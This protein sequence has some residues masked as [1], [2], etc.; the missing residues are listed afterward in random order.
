MKELTALEITKAII[1]LNKTGI[2]IRGHL[3]LGYLT[4]TARDV[5]TANV[6]F[7]KSLCGDGVTMP[8]AVLDLWRQMTVDLPADHWLVYRGG[9]HNA[10]TRHR[11][12]G[13]MWITLLP[14]DK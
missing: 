8:E 3:D 6:A 10:E 13:F 5:S 7:S 11:W 1:A 9:P 14:E 2:E 12:N 4:S